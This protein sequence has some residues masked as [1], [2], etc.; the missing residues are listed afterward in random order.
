MFVDVTFTA[1]HRRRPAM[2][3]VTSDTEIL[4]KWRVRVRLIT[5]V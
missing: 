1:V 2:G 4:A 5:I 3:H